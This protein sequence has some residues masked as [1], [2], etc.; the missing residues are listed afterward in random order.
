MGEAVEPA[1]LLLGR[2]DDGCGEEEE[3][4]TREG[5]SHRAKRAQRYKS[6]Q[7]LY[8]PRHGTRLA[9]TSIFLHAP[10]AKTGSRSGRIRIDPCRFPG[11][12]EELKMIRGWKG[13]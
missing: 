13:K 12:G 9:A 10:A 11:D 1:A 4:G 6:C 3:C 5:S 8:Q 2:S 7:P